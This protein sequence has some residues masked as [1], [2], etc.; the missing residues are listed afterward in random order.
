MRDAAQEL[1]AAVMMDDRLRHDR[2]EPGHSL[3]E[4]RRHAAIVQ[5]H[6]GGSGAAGHGVSKPNGNI[7]ATSMEEKPVRRVQWPASAPKRCLA[8]EWVEPGRS[9]PTRSRLSSIELVPRGELEDGVTG[10]IWSEIY[11][12]K[13]QERGLSPTDIIF[14]VYRSVLMANGLTFS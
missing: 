5:G 14:A 2:P 8:S 1:V 11:D 3:A 4:P 7:T 12:L 9:R 13:E 10:T 6:V